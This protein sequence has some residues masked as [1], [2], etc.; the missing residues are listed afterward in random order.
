VVRIINDAALVANLSKPGFFGDMDILE[1]GNG[2]LSQA[3]EETMFTMWCVLKS[4]L[5]LGND[6]SKMGSDTLRIVG[7][8]L[9]IKVN[10]DPLGTAA[11]IVFTEGSEKRGWAGPLAGGDTVAV[12]QNLGNSTV[13]MYMP[14]S[15]LGINTNTSLEVT[16]LWNGGPAKTYQHYIPASVPAHGV[17]AFRLHAEKEGAESS[18]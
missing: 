3:E 13:T 10:Q 11:R 16:D 12:L 8:S 2:G 5:L 6:L 4:P 14:W 9:L 17:A 7:N 15:A 1:I 18:D